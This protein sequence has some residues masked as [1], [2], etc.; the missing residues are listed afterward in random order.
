MHSATNL[1]GI[2]AAEG[3]QLSYAQQVLSQKFTPYVVA[4]WANTEAG[5]ADE[6]TQRDRSQSAE[7]RL[8]SAASFREALAQGSTTPAA[9]G[10]VA[11]AWNGYRLLLSI[12][13]GAA[14]LYVCDVGVAVSPGVSHFSITDVLV[15]RAAQQRAALAN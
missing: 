13:S 8:A 9:T 5:M 7:S 11:P 3:A 4:R 2:R 15:C 14:Q 12:R 6:S 10:L 1:L